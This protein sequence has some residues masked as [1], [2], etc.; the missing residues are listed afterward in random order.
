MRSLGRCDQR[1]LEAFAIFRMIPNHNLFAVIDNIVAINRTC[2]KQRAPIFTENHFV[3]RQ[4]PIP[5]SQ[6]RSHQRQ[7]E[8]FFRT[9]YLARGTL[10]HGSVAADANTV[11]LPVN[12][13]CPRVKNGKKYSAAV[14]NHIGF[15]RNFFSIFEDATYGIGY[16]TPSRLADEIERVHILQGGL[17]VSRIGGKS[18]I[19]TY[20]FAISSEHEK[21]PWQTFNG[22]E[23]EVFFVAHFRL[24]RLAQI[25]FDF[26]QLL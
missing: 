1:L 23:G 9:G 4:I 24:R 8:P 7:I 6:T 15:N 11:S 21:S 26:Q 3:R 18:F 10:T 2:I 25:D 20:Q 16:Q 19:P 17:R 14:A 5:D 22:G 13:E 12:I